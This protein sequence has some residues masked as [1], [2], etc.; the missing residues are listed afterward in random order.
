MSYLP[1]YIPIIHWNDT[2][3]CIQSYGAASQYA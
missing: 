1:E 3:T 2:S